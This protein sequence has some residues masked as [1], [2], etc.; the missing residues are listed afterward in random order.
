M[1]LIK[2]N[3]LI[4]WPVLIDIKD[5]RKHILANLTKKGDL[6]RWS[7]IDIQNSLDNNPTKKLK[8]I[9]VLANFKKHNNEIL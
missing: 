1:K 7:I 2:I 6:I 4:D 3:L 8:I 5:L 9:A